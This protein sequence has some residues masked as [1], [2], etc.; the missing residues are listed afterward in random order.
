MAARKKRPTLYEVYRPRQ[1]SAESS[2]PRQDAAK[3]TPAPS[4]PTDKPPAAPRPGVSPH[5]REPSPIIVSLSGPALA[6]VIAIIVVLL[7]VSF[8]AG[9]RYE[10]FHP[11]VAA[12]N[13]GPQAAKTDQDAA[14]PATGTTSA[15][16]QAAADR[17]PAGAAPTPSASKTAAAKPP[18]ASRTRPP[19]KIDLH[20]GYDYVVVQHFGRKR[21]DAIEV[22]R[23][24][25]QRGI[26][27]ARFG[28]NDIRLIVT[29]PFLTRQAD[30][31]AA[32]AERQR[33]E[34]LMQR[35]K[36]IGRELAKEWAAQGRPGYTLDGCYLYEI[37]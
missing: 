12:A 2:P 28:D 7:F 14:I 24:L 3:P 15:R 21:K 27:C 10:A 16:E 19:R 17:Q 36:Q 18:A 4:P 35:I 26:E 9:R 23:F 29:E 11:S 31:A 25:R 6:V 22:A 5:R 8:S 33:A 34:K 32:R 20:R 37:K 13:T 30:K 1:R